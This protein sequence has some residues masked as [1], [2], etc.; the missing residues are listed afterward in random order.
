[1]RNNIL[2]QSLQKSLDAAKAPTETAPP[3]PAPAADGP[4]SLR[5]MAD[6]LSSV[7]AQ[8]PQEIDP[9]EIADSEVADRFDIQDGLA[10]LI[11]SIRSSGQQLPAML[12]HRR[13]A[14]PRY[15]VVYGRRRIAAC[16]ALGIKVRAYIKE[17]SLDEALMSQA[18]ENSARLERSFIEQAV[19]AAKLEGA[20]FTPERICQ[21]LAID[22]STLSRLRTVVRDIPEQLILRI[23]AAQGVGRRPWMELRDL[24][25]GTTAKAVQDLIPMVPETGSATER[26]DVAINV[27]SSAKVK[28]ASKAQRVSAGREK[29]VVAGSVSYLRA[30]GNLVL[31]ADRKQDQAF[32]HYVETQ[33]S[34][35]Y[36]DWAKEGKKDANQLISND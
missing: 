28:E 20:G 34:R 31:R 25:K 4:K 11:E 29:T 27:L 7:S 12:R 30:T 32:L 22:P 21:A 10:D 35:L 13:G 1:M 6:V 16:R 24:I 15:E 26:L 2:A 8:A 18:L 36:L 17:M 14:G 5:S 23:G 19:F 3:S 9:V 33:L